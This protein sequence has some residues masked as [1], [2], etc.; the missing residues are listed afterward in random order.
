M[1]GNRRSTEK[2]ND[3]DHSIKFTCDYNIKDQSTIY[4][5]TTISLKENEINTDLCRKPTDR[6]QYLLPN[7]CHP[8]HI[9]T[10][11]HYSLALRILGVCSKTETLDK[12]L[13]E[14]RQMLLARK[15]NKKVINNA[16]EKVKTLDRT[17]TLLKVTKT[18]KKRVVLAITYH[19]KL[20]S[21]RQIV[22]KHWRT[23]T[24]DQ[25]M[26]RIYPEPPM[27]AY[28]QPPTLKN[29]LCR[30]NLPSNKHT[31]RRL[32]GM[33]ACHKPCHICPYICN[34][35]TYTSNHTKK[36]TI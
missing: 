14:L 9:F 12:R 23:L 16:I 32:T 5:D 6:V 33:K 25:K 10:N 29:M 27:I 34:I 21:I 1:D 36:H 20:P 31:K 35:K 7:S 15:Y 22:K 19:P 3:K 11:V 2:P 26:L 18:A 4:L 13:E 30:A 28:K 24:K 17:T 8:N